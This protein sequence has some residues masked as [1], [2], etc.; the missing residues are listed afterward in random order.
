MTTN[1]ES[2]RNN[3]TVAATASTKNTAAAPTRGSNRNRFFS[4]MSWRGIGSLGKLES[5]IWEDTR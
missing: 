4:L 2:T 5:L 1:D 3:G